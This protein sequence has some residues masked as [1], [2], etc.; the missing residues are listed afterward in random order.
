VNMRSTIIT[1][2]NLEGA[3]K[4]GLDMTA[5]TTDSDMGTK[6]DNLGK[7][8]PELLEEHTL[9]V[10]TAGA[11]GRQL[12]LS[13]YDLRD[14]NDLRRFPLTAIQCVG[15]NF[16]NQ[17]LSAAE[18]QSGV[19]DRSDF[20]DCQMVEADLR[21]ASFKYAKFS[22]ANLNGAR[23]GALEFLA[24]DK[25]YLKRANFSGANF[26]FASLQEADLRD[27]ILMGVDLS[28]L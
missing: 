24:G 9:W 22:R 25:K 23:L 13:G 19:F 14:V 4:F 12:D 7:T 2:A 15:A 20:R 26:R 5:A 1:G 10:A 11:S 18:L 28:G 8:L 6:L 3:E 17:D 21:G 27:A 16:L